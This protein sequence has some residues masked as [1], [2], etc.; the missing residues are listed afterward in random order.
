MTGRY[1]FVADDLPLIFY[2]MG[3]K[4]GRKVHMNWWCPVIG[5]NVHAYTF[6]Y[7]Y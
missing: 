5:V 7:T 4:N 1:L 6:I 3:K 2:F